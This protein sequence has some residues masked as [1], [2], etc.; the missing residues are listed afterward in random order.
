MGREGWSPLSLACSTGFSA[1]VA[2]LL[3]AGADRNLAC[4]PSTL[5]LHLAAYGGGF[6]EVIRMLL[7]FGVDPISWSGFYMTPSRLLDRLAD[8]N[9]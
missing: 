9:N 2:S 8:F 6:L 7:D 1:L 4:S 3:Q 5:P